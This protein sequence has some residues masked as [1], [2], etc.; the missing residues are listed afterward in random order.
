MIEAKTS[1]NLSSKRKAYS[2][3][4][5]SRAASLSTKISCYFVLVTV[6]ILLLSLLDSSET[7]T[8]T[9]GIRG[10]HSRMLAAP[11]LSGTMPDQKIGGLTVFQ[12]PLPAGLFTD[13]DNDQLTYSASL[14]DGSP[15]PSWIDFDTTNLVFN[16]IA[17][18]EG[19]YTIRVIAQDAT[20]SASTT[21]KIIVGNAPPIIDI[22]KQ[23]DYPVGTAFTIT[24][25]IRD[26][27][28]DTFN[29]SAFIA[30]GQAL[31]SWITY[32]PVLYQFRGTGPEGQTL[33]LE[34]RADDG[35]DVAIKNFTLRIIPPLAAGPPLADAI[36]Y[37]A[38]GPA[39]YTI[40]PSAF[41]IVNPEI[42]VTRTD[43]KP[44]PTW[45]QFFDENDTFV[46]YP[47]QNNKDPIPITIM[48]RDSSGNTAIQSFNI[49]TRNIEVISQSIKDE[50]TI[51]DNRVSSQSLNSVNVLKTGKFLPIWE[52][53][54][55]DG[56]EYGIYAKLIDQKGN[57]G[58]EFRINDETVNN[59]A[60]PY[61]V[62]L[63]NGS[64][65]I[66]WQSNMTDG[67]HYGVYAKI[68]DT[69]GQVVTPDFL[70]NTFTYE[71]QSAP[72]AA[73]F[74]NGNVMIVWQ[75]YSQDTSGYGVYGKI[76]D[77]T[78]RE[79]MME[80]R[81]NNYINSNQKS[82]IISI[83][84]GGNALVLWISRFQ[85]G[86]DYG[87]FGKII[88]PDGN[89]VVDEFQVNG[90]FKSYQNSP[91]ILNL[92][93]ENVLIAWQSNT[94]DG[95]GNGIYAKIIDPMNNVVTPEFRINDYTNLDQ[96][97]FQMGLLDNGNVF[98][99]WQSPR[100]TSANL[101]GI[102]AK[103][104]DPNGHTV[105]PEYQINDYMGSDQQFPALAIVNQSYILVAWESY[106]QDGDG[107]G[108]YGKILDM[109]GNSVK[110]QFQI[111]DY[112]KG[113]QLA[114][115]MA[116]LDDKKVFIGWSSET[117]GYS[118]DAVGKI[119]R[120]DINALPDIIKKL[121]DHSVLFN[122]TFK[123]T[124]PKEYVLE[125]EGEKITVTSTQPDGSPLPAWLTFNPSTYTFSGT[126]TEDDEGNFTVL[127][128]VTDARNGT[129]QQTFNVYVSGTRIPLNQTLEP[130]EEPWEELG[131]EE[132]DPEIEDPEDPE[133][134][135]SKEK[136]SFIDK[137][138]FDW[139]IIAAALAALLLCLF[140]ICCCCWRR[141]K[142]QQVT[143]NPLPP[144]P[145]YPYP[146]PQYPTFIATA[147]SQMIPIN[148]EQDSYEEK[149]RRKSRRQSRRRSRSR[150]SSGD[151][152]PTR[153]DSDRH[154][155]EGAS[156]LVM[157]P[158]N[159]IC[160]LTKCIM[161]DPWIVISEDQMVMNSYEREAIQEWF[162]QYDI[163]PITKKKKKWMGGNFPLKK[164]IDETLKR[165]SVQQLMADSKLRKKIGDWL[166]RRGIEEVKEDPELRVILENY[167]RSFSKSKNSN[168]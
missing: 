103:I 30:G 153:A 122:E 105:R 6:P 95:S 75:S 47:H 54:L 52:S 2:N 146:P 58:E 28:E 131:E 140:C 87:I 161:A 13:P 139:R 20:A 38:G 41:T 110:P 99:V 59:Q 157:I 19:N 160:P 121:P 44:F 120:F 112:T 97:N 138:P 3:L 36:L 66:T 125:Y 70:V 57:A 155:L 35:K 85:D 115:H 129:T 23:F 51:N 94:A 92:Q 74:P 9:P 145:N 83:I 130:G 48:A 118:F 60:Y 134:E 133:K 148:R 91:Q 142:Q 34:I 104:I 162:R 100:M 111:N 11:Q 15:L 81:L 4:E 98:F 117:A 37:L 107:L 163:D 17:P 25:Q 84:G 106:E 61:S 65:L 132:T 62:A 79:V 165:I 53:Y 158:E 8:K 127:F 5:S 150:S 71:E 113:W 114:V 90:Y 154:I 164:D 166:R 33:V 7:F 144:N 21:F 101:K 31:P 56:S 78:G 27:N 43:S 10:T 14:G 46:A 16:G 151:D 76:Y 136:E 149:P 86:D 72:Q 29:T 26:P 40:P 89:I 102:Y 77:E 22:G 96:M 55:Q 1:Q 156:D 123:F 143:P 63:L 167:K 82:P 80:T 39:E 42:V 18:K 168:L 141:R 73:Q 67:D 152:S 69:Q 45:L 49:I 126:P 108:I 124:V 88:S 50:F 109:N 93:N 147:P 24:A 128:K 12:I 68:I 137:L 135:P 64:I 116:G 119:L 159:F 32:D